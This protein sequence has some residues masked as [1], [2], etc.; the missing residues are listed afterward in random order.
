MFISA[1]FPRV[2]PQLAAAAAAAPP[3]HFTLLQKRV[4]GL[5]ATAAASSTLILILRGTGFKVHHYQGIITPMAIQ[6]SAS[7]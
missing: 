5:D 1:V 3:A 4:H 6:I 2:S 7:F